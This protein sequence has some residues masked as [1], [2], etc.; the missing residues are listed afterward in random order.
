VHICYFIIMPM[1]QTHIQRST[2]KGQGWRSIQH[3]QPVQ[4]ILE[5]SNFS[6][7]VVM[8]LDIPSEGQGQSKIRQ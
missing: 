6:G 1:D 7:Y 5:K 4:L 2:V 3:E 8:T